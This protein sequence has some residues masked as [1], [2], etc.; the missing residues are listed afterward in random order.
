MDEDWDESKHPRG[1][2]DNA[3]EFGK[4]AGGGK[5]AKPAAKDPLSFHKDPKNLPKGWSFNKDI[6]GKPTPDGNHYYTGRVDDKGYKE[7]IS[8]RD[9][10]GPS[11]DHPD[12]DPALAA[13]QRGE[14]TKYLQGQADF[15]HTMIEKNKGNPDFD[16]K[17]WSNNLR[18]TLARHQAHTGEA[19]TPKP[20]GPDTPEI[21]KSIH[22]LLHPEVSPAVK[23]QI[24]K[25]ADTKKN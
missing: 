4:G 21:V 13:K 6:S 19:Y 7:L 5:T 2:P 23:E 25:N 22:G 11:K 20:M 14:M 15:R 18:N 16:K 8:K 17:K 24:A 1:Q 12:Y 9:M 3:G 10:D